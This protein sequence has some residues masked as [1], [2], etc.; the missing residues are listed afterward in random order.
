MSVDPAEVS[1]ALAAESQRVEW[2]QSAKDAGEILQ[3]ACAF[4]NDL[5]G[6]GQPGYLVIGVDKRGS[7]VGADA[8]DEALQKLVNRL[9][10]TRILPN[11]SFSVDALEHQGQTIVIVSVEP[12]PVPPIVKFDGVPWV[13]VGTSTRR[14]TDA[15]L[16]R[17][18]ERRPESRLPFDLRP[19]HGASLDDL[20][21]S[22][23][24]MDYAAERSADQDGESFPDLEVWLGQRE[25]ARR[26]AAGWAPTTTGI[27]VYGID[28]QAH[29][30]GAIV[31]FVRYAGT[32][33]DAPVASRK[34]ASGRLA[35]QLETLWTQLGANL[36]QL[37][38]PAAG[39]RSPFT[40]E[41]PLEALKE[42][43]RNLVQHRLYEGT[44]APGRVSWFDDR[45]IFS[46]PGPPFGQASEGDFGAHSDYR[47]PTVTGLLVQL[48]YV[49]RLGRG[50]R[51]AR[52]LLAANGNPDLE[53]ETD[54]YTTVCVRRHR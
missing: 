21:L 2:K 33:L 15:D 6:N 7:A 10:S 13:R 4:A 41:Y 36:A 1:R 12:Y 5:A 32:D 28:P 25:L 53:A 37:P 29:F 18:H 38:A 46:N 17:L 50:I 27:L 3:A 26:T 34:T 48:G 20:D 22:L 40:P 19:C 8:S 23:L 16:V 9:T 31:E 54:G 11:P 39:I 43:A 30:P 49:E 51:R 42:L 24:R 14:A 47:N 52:K 45:V 35:D 44:N